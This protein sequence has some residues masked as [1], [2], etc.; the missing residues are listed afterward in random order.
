[1]GVKKVARETLIKDMEYFSP[2][3]DWNKIKNKLPQHEILLNEFDSCIDSS[4]MNT[5]FEIIK[6]VMGVL[7]IKTSIHFDFETPN[8]S[9]DRTIE[10]CKKYGAD[11][12]YSGIS[13][14]NYLDI[15]KFNYNNI[16]LEFQNEEKMIKKPILKY[17][18]EL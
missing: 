11:V 13:G 1:M 10:I 9:T 5:N 4:L 6:R 17:L 3:S 12:Y 8:S 2:I 14:A 18:S 16:K 7:N 15:E